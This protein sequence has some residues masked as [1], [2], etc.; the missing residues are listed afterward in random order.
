[1]DLHG[2]V[3][4]VTGASS[5]IG[6]ETAVVLARA[7]MHVVAVARRADRLESLAKEV[8]GIDPYPADLTKLQSVQDLHQY[9]VDIHGACHVLINNAGASL[10]DAFTGE[11]Q[12]SDM[13]REI[14]LNYVAPLRLMATFA[15][16]LRESRPARVINVASVAGRAPVIGPGYSAAKAALIALSE[17]TNLTW[18]DQGVTVSQVNPGLI[19]TEG[20]SQSEFMRT[21]LR[22][23][24]GQ[25]E[26]VA[27]AIRDVAQKGTRERTVPR[28]YRAAYVIRHVAP[29]VYFAAAKGVRKFRV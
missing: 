25:P 18:P 16:L 1:M 17:A 19:A 10:A 9:V 4:V 8:P 20:F 6:R 13:E 7:G 12:R 2:K 5:G 11:A 21:P 15:D 27:K 23:L 22:R 24:I 3:A 28:W 26:D 29:P 14:Q